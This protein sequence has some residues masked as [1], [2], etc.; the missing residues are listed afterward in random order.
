MGSRK[1]E[2]FPEYLMR[3]MGYTKI[4]SFST[5]AEEICHE[6]SFAPCRHGY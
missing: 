1:Q 6:I 3:L 5:Q 2:L 4:A